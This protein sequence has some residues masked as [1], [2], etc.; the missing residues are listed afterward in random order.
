MN[1]DRFS[2]RRGTAIIIVLALVVL[3]T[4]L[5]VAFFSLAISNR[6]LANSSSAKTRAEVLA[7]NT[8]ELV[9]ASLRTEIERGSSTEARY[10]PGTAA[11]FYLPNNPRNMLPRRIGNALELSDPKLFNLNR[12]S[13]RQS[14]LDAWRLND[15][16]LATDFPAGFPGDLVASD[17]ST[18]DP[19]PAG[20]S[21]GVNRWNRGAFFDASSTSFQSPDW[22][23]ITRAGPKALAAWN[24]PLAN[25]TNT[26]NG[27]FVLGRVAFMI[28]DQG[29]LLN[30]NAAGFPS[31]FGTAN[32]ADVARKGSVALAD[33]TAIPG[34]DTAANA[35]LLVNWRNRTSGATP[36]GFLSYLRDWLPV[37]GFGKTYVS[38]TNS[39][40]R[41]LSRGDLLS[42]IE[43]TAPTINRLA[44]Q[45]LTTFSRQRNRP[46][47]APTYDAKDAAFGGSSNAAFD[48]QTNALAGTTSIQPPGYPSAF[49]NPNVLAG[50]VRVGN[51]FRRLDGSQAASNTPL[52]SRRF[53]LGRLGWIGANGFTP[54][55]TTDLAR[56][57]AIRVSNGA[58]AIASE[59]ELIQAAFGLVWQTDSDPSNPRRWV[60]AGPSGNTPVDSIKTLTEIAAEA[61]GRE[62]NFFELLK[63]GMLHGSLGKTAG[64]PG[65]GVGG[66]FWDTA[67]RTA[68]VD[69]NPDLQVVRVGANMIDQADADSK[70]TTIELT[71]N[72][73][74]KPVFAW[75]KENLPYIHRMPMLIYRPESGGA[76]RTDVG[77]WLIPEFWNPHQNASTPA[78][79]VNSFRFVA[80]SGAISASLSGVLNIPP[81]Q[82]A[83]PAYAPPITVAA[84]P[85]PLDFSKDFAA[86]SE[87][88]TFSSSSAFSFSTPQSCRSNYG[89]PTS[90]S[91]RNQFSESTT[92]FFGINLNYMTAVN[93]NP[94]NF[95]PVQAK[96]KFPYARYQI[97]GAPNNFP[98]FE[99][100]FLDSGAPPMWRTYDSLQQVQFFYTNTAPNSDRDMGPF[101]SAS[102][103]GNLIK[104]G[105]P[106]NTRFGAVIDPFFT[107]PRNRTLRPAESFPDSN[108]GNTQDEVAF[109]C[110]P[111]STIPN[112]GLTTPAPSNLKQPPSTSIPDPANIV[113]SFAIAS[114]WTTPVQGR[115]VLSFTGTVQENHLARSS[116]SFAESKT[117]YSDFDGITRPA[118]AYMGFFLNGTTLISHANAM[119]TS[120]GDFLN[121]RPIILNRPFRSV[122]EL[123]YVFRDQPWKSL[124]FF[125]PYSADDGLLDLFCIN[126]VAVEEGQVNI[127]RTPSPV[128]KGILK[129]A[130]VD[131]RSTGLTLDSVDATVTAI[132]SRMGTPESTTP[133]LSTPVV[134]RGELARRLFDVIP[135][136]TSSVA[137]PTAN[138]VLNPYLKVRREAVLRSLIETA[139]TT[140]WNLAIDVIAQSGRYP[141]TATSLAGFVV[142]A[143]SRYW[144]H[145]AIDRMTGEVVDYQW[146][147]VNE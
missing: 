70:P 4:F 139:G 42:Y 87:S 104:F 46:N 142:D 24:P 85:A 49:S 97:A 74:A 96:G 54:Q 57:N 131:D 79:D 116:E 113:P 67:A 102:V 2:T 21:I 3:L 129:G 17:V 126:D 12:R 59:E 93:F 14:G 50:N 68:D 107:S 20:K 81:A 83:D 86:N 8:A 45:Y 143:E 141:T 31:S 39:D 62:P 23:L 130:G 137:T 65:S 124:D 120:G 117:R 71:N 111:S 108:R 37:N 76:T 16:N 118:D 98:S 34:I 38:G 9:V 61:T 115:E 66:Y 77:W 132:Q 43:T 64:D 138:T 55:A 63:L 99:L 101:S 89:G 134:S 112:Q 88:I 135:L 33:L 125:S 136:P 25:G 128:L 47:W 73:P 56:I 69:Q 91:A 121:K 30:M 92:D 7:R 72:S 140:T 147:V 103:G 100:Q 94:V 58:S 122:G 80:S 105:D 114:G 28:F 18:A 15:P 82:N 75:G 13:M 53:P 19:N 35:N 146:E 10:Q 51:A 29:G 44:L 22:I 60:Y 145:V 95:P 11:S 27:D 119:Q 133:V 6:Q 41:F 52:V 1:I 40:N 78:T 110:A 26:A 106:R 48:Y 90:P 36:A 5:V 123:G 127:N 84:A 32:A 109:V 144:L